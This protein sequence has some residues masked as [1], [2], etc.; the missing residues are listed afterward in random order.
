MNTVLTVNA[1]YGNN[2]Q[3]VGQRVG[4]ERGL[5][6][7][8]LQVDFLD[9]VKRRRKVRHGLK[10]SKV[11]AVEIVIIAVDELRFDIVRG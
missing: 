2:V 5:Y 4:Y 3:E 6:D 1:C 11:P 8:R 7:V 10:M 9:P